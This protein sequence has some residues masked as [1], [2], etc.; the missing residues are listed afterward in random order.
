MSHIVSV[1]GMEIECLYASEI[2]D[3]MNHQRKED[4]FFTYGVVSMNLLMEAQQDLVLRRYID[5][6]DG[7]IISEM[8][9]LRAAGMEDEQMMQEVEESAFFRSLLTMLVE[10]QCP[11]F[12]LGETEEEANGFGE[13][14][15]E[16][17]IDF[18]VAGVDYLDVTDEDNVDRV[19]NEINSL[20]PAMV[21]TCGQS[22]SLERF[23]VEHR[24]K[25]NTRF[26]LGLGGFSR[27]AEQ[28]GM[29]TGWLSK[30]LEKAAFRK[31]V[32]QYNSE[33]GGTSL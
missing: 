16:K 15:Q 12:L 25:I 6:L 28:L 13:Y 7:G 30:L 10:S 8:E 32:N 11:V 21:I 9:V 14:L 22:F 23:V 31:L 24:K 3:K 20:L 33:N 17:H 2:M 27:I 29:K 5:T 1:L 19:I 26:W 18:P 4:G